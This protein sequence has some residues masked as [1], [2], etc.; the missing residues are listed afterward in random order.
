MNLN[1][2]EQPNSAYF[3]V[4]SPNSIALLPNYVTVII[5]LVISASPC[6]S[7]MF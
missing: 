1:D 5:N 2:L 3:V 4:F 6:R 7:V